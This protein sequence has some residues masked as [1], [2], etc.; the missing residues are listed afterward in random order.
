SAE[1]SPPTVT[2]GGDSCDLNEVREGGRV[3]EERRGCSRNRSYT[4]IKRQV[5]ATMSNVEV[6]KSAK[7]SHEIPTTKALPVSRS[8]DRRY[9]EVV[10]EYMRKKQSRQ[11]SAS[12]YI[13]QPSEVLTQQADQSGPNGTSYVSWDP[14]DTPRSQRPQN[15]EGNQSDAPL[16]TTTAPGTPEK[17]L[18]VPLLDVSR[19]SVTPTNRSSNEDSFTTA[20]SNLTRSRSPQNHGSKSAVGSQ[21]SPGS[22]FTYYVTPSTINHFHGNLKSTPKEEE[23]E[24]QQQQKTSTFHSPGSRANGTPRNTSKHPAIK[25]ISAGGS[26]RH[27]LRATDNEGNDESHST[28]FPDQPFFT[29]AYFDHSVDGQSEPQRNQQ[30]PSPLTNTTTGNEEHPVIEGERYSQE[31]S[32]NSSPQFMPFVRPLALNFENASDRGSDTKS[33]RTMLGQ[34]FDLRP[35]QPMLGQGSAEDSSSQFISCRGSDASQS[36]EEAVGTLNYPPD[37]TSATQYSI[38][39]S[40]SPFSATISS[41]LPWTPWSGGRNTSSRPTTPEDIRALEKT[42]RKQKRIAW[43]FVVSALI[44][45][46]VTAATVLALEIPALKNK[47]PVDP[48][49]HVS[50][51]IMDTVSEMVMETT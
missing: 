36:L 26:P 47:E 24:Q 44:L 51:V 50:R 7:E 6:P 14:P 48:L 16:A 37:E 2:S 8:T 29:P 49:P 18:G 25:V 32:I 21:R 22:P 13:I 12:S 45:L 38:N 23:E 19:G 33:D 17:D 39:F 41:P 10:Q 4:F 35:H 46:V 27:L 20:K 42:L 3:S 31:A 34:G 28:P 11:G 9:S 1:E 43:C 15:P 5:N 40:N 30:R